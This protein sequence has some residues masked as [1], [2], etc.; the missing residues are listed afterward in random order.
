MTPRVLIW[1]V[2]AVAADLVSALRELLPGNAVEAVT[3]GPAGQASGHARATGANVVHIVAP[4]DGSDLPMGPGGEN[5]DD[6]AVAES[7][8]G[9]GPALASVV[10]DGCYRPVL[11]ERIALGGTAVLGLPGRIGRGQATEFALAWY[12]GLAGNPA[13]P[14]LPAR[15]AFDHAMQATRFHRLPTDVQPQFL[16]QGTAPGTAFVPRPARSPRTSPSGTART[17]G[18]GQTPLTPSAQSLTTPST[19]DLASST[20]PTAYR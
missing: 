4:D 1:D 17:D 12:A 6:A 5:G 16:A 9:V 7:L 11:A 18:R 10:L 19:W 14:G 2:A 8:A 15:A 20:C 13:Q 3:G